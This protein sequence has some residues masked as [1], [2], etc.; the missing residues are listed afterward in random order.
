MTGTIFAVNDISGVPSIEVFD[1]GKVQVAELFGNVLIGTSTDNTT[2]KLQVNGNISGTALVS[3]ASAGDEGGEIRL[4]KAVTN[5]TLT[6]GVTIDVHQNKLRIFETG[7]TNRGLYFD[8]TAA[9]AAISTNGLAPVAGGGG[10]V[11]SVGLSL[12]NIFSVT[13]SPVTTSGTLTATLAS[14]TANTFLAAP[15]GAAGAPTMRAIVAADIPTLNQNT[16]GTAA[17]VTGTVAIANGGTGATT[18]Q[19]AMD[20]LAGATTAGQYL[21]GDGTDVVMSAIQA[22]DVPTL[23]Q[24]TTGSAATLT[25]GRTIALTGDVTYTSGSFNGSANVTG[26]AT[27]ASVGTA[28]TYTKVTTDAKGRVTSGT[29]L[30]AADIPSLDASKI[31]TG[32]IDAARLP[33]YVDDVIEGANLAAFPAT[34]ETGKIYVALDT[35]KTYRWS[36]S[37]YVYITSGAVDSVAGKT[38]VVTLVKGDVGLGNVDNTADSTKNVSS[39]ATLT[40][41]RTI[42]GVSFNGSANI[43]VAD[44]T[45]QPLDADLT[46]IAALAGTSG[47]LRKTAADTWS[48]DTNAYVTSSGVTSVTG[49]APIVS[50]GGATPAI[51]I[52]AATTSAAGS[53]SSADKTKLDG[54]ASGATANTGTVT[55]V[56][57]GTGLTGGTIT[58]SGTI[59]L[60]NTAVTA[61]SY[62]LANITV[63]AQGRITAATNGSA[64]VTS[65]VAGNAIT[66]S[67]ATGAVTINHSDTSSQASVDNSN[68]TVIQ[69]ITLDTFGHITGIASLNL[70]D[71]YYTETEAD[72]RFVNTTGDTMTGFLTLHADPTNALHATTKQYVDNVAAGLKSAPAVEAATTANLTAT[73]NNGTAGVGATLTATVNGAFPAIDGVTV[74]VTTIGLNGVLVKNQTNSAHNG[75]Y[76]LTQVGNA[77]TPWILTR[78]GVCDQSSEI[79]GSYVFVKAGTTLNGTGW[80]AYV[81]SPSTFTV[82]TDNITYFQFSGAGTYTAGSGLTLTGTQFSHTDTSSV[83]NVDNSGNTFIQDLTFDTFGHVTGVVSAAVSIPATNIAQGTR[84]TTTVPI[85]SSTGTGATLSEA[86]TS[87]AGVMTSADKTKLDGIAT[88]A[89]ANTG[90]VTSVGGTGTVSGLTLSGT[91]TTSGNLTLGGTLAVAA[92]NFASQTANTVL[93]A[94]NGTAGVP[95]FRTL[96][97]ADIP[98]LNQNTTG[99]AATLTTA[100]TIQT[101]LASTS[102]AS[103]NG[104]A[105]ITPGVTGTLPVANGGTGVTTSTGSGSNVLNTSPSLTTPNIGAASGT[106]LTLTGALQ[107]ATKSFLIPHPTKPGMQLRYGSLEG[108][109]N[110]VYIRGK[111]KGKSKIELP[112]Y[113]TKLVDPDSITVTLTPIG[114][115]QKLYVEDIADNVVTVANDGLFAGE[116]NCF[117]VVYGERVDVDK[118]VVEIE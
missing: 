2:D 28:G 89:T 29:T 52:S 11:T 110:G 94:P 61:G 40:T 70:D 103:F 102:S 92:S 26:T 35:N 31:T 112:E 72:S 62:T 80:V 49:T 54:I 71:R 101:N 75:R 100:R 68:G 51:S 76:N 96:V 79:P 109:E 65:I 105:N 56:A 117:F 15:N 14:Q 4:N 73:Y 111:L 113:W 106:S 99:S 32:T 87:L 58:T 69:D 115:H 6:T 78:C 107:A 60:A 104:S 118:L 90:T 22:A 9:G 98:T 108:P 30:V 38:G 36:G 95:T 5:T 13:G 59:S 12:P 43:T 114:K 48:L 57:T 23:N 46:A 63:D 74:S 77:S 3:T 53:M 84:T 10:T 50:S 64:G 25:T 88:G 82:G 86:T 42:N 93:A 20:A 37:A 41:A 85:T 17:N 97:A 21:R 24:N 44:S 66:I 7:G 39:A 27:L 1:S 16:T 8:L 45:K 18:R 83:A 91:V 47:L 81:A 33:S 55:S 116:I 34:G 67:G 19:A